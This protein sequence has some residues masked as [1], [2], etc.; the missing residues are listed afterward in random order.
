MVSRQYIFQ[1]TVPGEMMDDADPR[2][3]LLDYLKRTTPKTI[4][5]RATILQVTK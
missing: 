4:A 2:E 1:I 3:W 5:R